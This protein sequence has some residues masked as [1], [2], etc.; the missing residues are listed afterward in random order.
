MAS[1][2][3][4]GSGSNLDL[5]A[6]LTNLVESEKKPQQDL[7]SGRK[8]LADAT[9]SAIG[10]LKS[11]LSSFRDSLAKLKDATFYTGKSAT[12]S[13]A[14]LFTVSAKTTAD[15]GNYTVGVVN[16]AKANKIA[17]AANFAAPT[18]TVGS[19]TLT[20]GVGGN[21]FNVAVTAG[22]NDTVTGIRD[23]INNAS[24]NTGVKA[25]LLT[26]N[27][28][29]TS[30][31][32]LVLTSTKTGAASQISVSVADNDGNNTDAAGLSQLHYAIGDLNNRFTEVNP[33]LDAKITV[34]GFEV[35]SATNQFVD[36]IDGVTITAVKDAEDPLDPPTGELKVSEDKTAIKTA[37]ESFVKSYNDLNTAFNAFL[38]YNAASETGGG[39][40]GDSSLLAIQRKMKQI[41]G[42]PVSGA[43]TDFNTLA[44]LGIATN[45]DGSLTINSAKL[46]SAIDTRFDDVAK[47]FSGTNGAGG[48]FDAYLGDVIGAGGLLQNRQDTLS[49]QLRKLADQQ[50]ALDKRIE[51]FTK[52]Y[53][54][55]FTAL[56][57]LVA[58]LN[59]TGNF[60]TQQ[61]DAAAKIIT[62]KSD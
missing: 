42:E 19:G 15:A 27:N 57:T 16:L 1:I 25:S 22:V 3:S 41:L 13:D 36:V 33:A 7:I 35:T 61:L 9:V 39:L 37:I 54:D 28:G 18:T 51:V 45:K 29:G 58:Q 12:S 53:R 49:T 55:Q 40:S 59:Q 31:T 30:A 38:T 4:L 14:T 60:L 17:S 8:A 62:R 21:T 44:F 46:T 50:A 47:L 11:K 43:A 2:T 34:D 56:D 26:V 10:T 6:L 20:I 23:A 24:T 48:K 5:E 52:R 32:K